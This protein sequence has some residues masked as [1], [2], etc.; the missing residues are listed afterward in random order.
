MTKG[1]KRYAPQRKFDFFFYASRYQTWWL[2][3][4]LP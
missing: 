4:E 1:E 2:S 3:L